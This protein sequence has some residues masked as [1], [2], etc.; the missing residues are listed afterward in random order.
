MLLKQASGRYAAIDV[1]TTGFSPGRG[2][3][4]VEVGSAILEGGRIVDEFHSLVNPGRG[5]SFQA[6][7]VNGITDEM[8]AGQPK[9]ENVFPELHRFIRG[10]VLVAHNAGFDLSFLRHEFGRLGL[11][12]NHRHACT[13]ELSRLRY[14]RLRDHKL[15]TVFRHV[16]GTTACVQQHRALADARMVAAIWLAMEGR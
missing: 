3:R 9:P 4:I 10:T 16:A 8:L 15:E 6:Q 12:C 11:A 7:Q 1:E 5:I 2:D 13:L 14:P